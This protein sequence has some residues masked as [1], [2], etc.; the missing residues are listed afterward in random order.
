PPSRNPPYGCVEVRRRSDPLVAMTD[1][2]AIDPRGENLCVGR[3]DPDGSRRRIA[4]SGSDP[5][6]GGSSPRLSPGTH[7]VPAPTQPHPPPAA[8]PAPPRR[9]RPGIAPS[10]C[11]ATASN[12]ASCPIGAA[13]C[14]PIGCPLLDTATG[15]LTA[16]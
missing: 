3:G 15:K 7:P 14:T 11:L 2:V 5:T 13:I 8:P 12:L 1:I 6:R 9:A 10:P 16:G 4:A